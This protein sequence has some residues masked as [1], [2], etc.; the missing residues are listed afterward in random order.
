MKII[1][2]ET[3]EG[4]GLTGDEVNVKPGFARNFLVPQGIA[5][6]GNRFY[7][8]LFEAERAELLRKD[9]ERKVKAE[10]VASK[11][12]GAEIEFVVHIGN[13]GQMFGA[14]TKADIAEKLA[15]QEIEIDRRKIILPE[16]IKS[17]GEHTVKVKPHGAVAFD[18]KVIVTPDALPEETEEL[19]IRQLVNGEG[20]LSPEERAA[21]LA[22]AAE[23]ALEAAAEGEEATPEAEVEEAA[24]E[25]V[26]EVVEEA[27]DE[28]AEEE[29]KEEE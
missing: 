17:I 28:V 11:G 6:P 26:E 23:E 27:T 24:E 3:Y 1:L 20:D 13:R 12:Q 19:T 5:Y 21:L 9:E 10:A 14:I 29:K 25:V 15:E 18:V 22:E 7:R 8:K 2:R 4:L 16:P